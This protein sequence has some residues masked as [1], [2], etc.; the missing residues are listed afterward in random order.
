MKRF[1]CQ[2][3]QEI[4]FENSHCNRCGS[5]LGFDPEQRQLLS[6][7]P[8]SNDVFS[9]Q[10]GD[11]KRCQL[12]TAPVHCN[13]L[14][15]LNSRNQQCAS[16]RLTQLIPNQNTLINQRRWQVLESAKRRLLYGLLSLKLPVFD[17]EPRLIFE[18]LEDQQTNPNVGLEHVLSGHVNG[19]ITLNAAEADGSYREAAR[20][21]MNEPYRTLLGHFRHEVGHFYWLLLIRDSAKSSEFETLFGNPHQEYSAALNHYYQHGPAQHWQTTFISAYASA[22]PLEDWAETWAHY[23]LMQETLETALAFDLISQPEKKAGD[24]LWM[25]EWYQLVTILNALNR[26]TGNADAYPFV[27]SPVVKQKLQF[28]DNLIHPTVR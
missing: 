23:L 6:L 22:H 17:T 13:W 15:P 2:C 9:T 4:F 19:R 1:F 12:H 3:G 18:F 10:Q 8:K 5:L 26:S 27:I 25:T 11:F 7:T 14:I 21:A 28:I 24:T 20:E 16:C